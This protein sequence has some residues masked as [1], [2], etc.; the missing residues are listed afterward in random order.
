MFVHESV[1][2]VSNMP[3]NFWQPIRHC[4]WAD[5]NATRGKRTKIWGEIRLAQSAGHIMT[6]VKAES[7]HLTNK[8]LPTQK[9]FIQK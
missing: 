9:I 6:Y 2:Q 4:G 5:D 1:V 7:K 3:L 8:S